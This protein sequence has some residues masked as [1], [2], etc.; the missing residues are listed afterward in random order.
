MQDIRKKGS[1]IKKGETVI[2]IGD[3][4]GPIDLGILASIGV[5]H[6]PVY[7][8]PKVAIL[9]TGDEVIYLSCFN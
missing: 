1:D 5:T 8:K 6:V 3:K 7:R 2:K 4:I 9:S